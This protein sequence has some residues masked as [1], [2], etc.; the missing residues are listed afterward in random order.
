[1]GAGRAG[2]PAEGRRD[3]ARV[4]RQDPG[5]DTSASPRPR[6]GLLLCWS[7]VELVRWSV[8]GAVTATLHLACT[9]GV[10]VDRAG[11]GVMGL[12]GADG[13]CAAVAELVGDVFGDEVIGDGVVACGHRVARS[14][15]WARQSW[16][17]GPG[18]SAEGCWYHEVPAVGAVRQGPAHGGSV[19]DGVFVSV[20][21][22]GDP[23]AYRGGVVRGC[24][25]GGAAVAAQSRGPE[26]E[27]ESSPVGGM[28]STMPGGR[29]HRNIGMS[30]SVTSAVF[31]CRLLCRC[32][33]VVVLFYGTI[34]WPRTDPGGG[35][36]DV[37]VAAYQVGA[38]SCAAFHDGGGFSGGL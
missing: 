12:L 14:V 29:W 7:G 24:A 22:A 8:T 1:M 31:C 33:F 13:A 36:G 19:E 37:G 20:A 30:L 6:R 35:N 32:A 26:A 11:P 21:G 5:D 18:G 28:S 2:G 23:G 38:G 4:R 10:S 17:C 25:G 27:Q 16:Q 3:A 34:R 9:D 15:R